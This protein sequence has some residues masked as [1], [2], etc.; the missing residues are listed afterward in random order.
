VVPRQDITLYNDASLNDYGAKRTNSAIPKLNLTHIQQAAKK[1]GKN[2]DLQILLNGSSL[3]DTKKETGSTHGLI[4]PRVVKAIRNIDTTQGTTC[5]SS[6]I[7]SS[8][9]SVHS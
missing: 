9:R 1:L 2:T 8:N 7:E 5:R 6:A 4:I 3:E